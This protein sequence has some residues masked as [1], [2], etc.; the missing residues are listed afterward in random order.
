MSPYGPEGSPMTLLQH[1]END[2]DWAS[3]PSP[4]LQDPGTWGFR[5]SGLR[6]RVVK[7]LGGGG[8]V[9]GLDPKLE[10]DF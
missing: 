6:D 10:P 2:A 7:F 1:P 9:C 4:R 3:P 8:E 5:D